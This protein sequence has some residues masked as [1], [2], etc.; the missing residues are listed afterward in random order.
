MPIVGSFAGASAR[1][2]GLG[3]GLALPGDFESIATQTVGS[4]GAA[5]VTFSSIPATYT[6]LQIR[7]IN[8]QASA[9]SIAGLSMWFNNDTARNYSRH[10]LVGN[11]S[12]ASSTGL[13][14]ANN[15]E[16]LLFYAGSGSQFG[17]AVVDILDYTNTNKNKASRSICGTDNNGSGFAILTSGVWLNTAAITTITIASNGSTISEYSSFALYG[18]K[19]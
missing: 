9:T 3:A 7:V 18:V 15:G 4:G 17:P 13:L 11:G 14:A 12:S 10:E 2:Y 1:S 16:E 5:S 19:A 8:K 6:H